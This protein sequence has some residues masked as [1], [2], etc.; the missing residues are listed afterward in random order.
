[1]KPASLVQLAVIG[2]LAGIVY[3]EES[4]SACLQ[5]L[6]Q[7]KQS[8]L[9]KLTA[10]GKTSND[11]IAGE[12]GTNLTA[13]FEAFKKTVANSFTEWKTAIGKEFGAA[14]QSVAKLGD[15]FQQTVDAFTPATTTTE[16]PGLWN[17]IKGYVKSK[18]D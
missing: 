11:A 1:M 17:R 15:A 13:E 4:E 18:I 8:M 14:E 7:F 12:T 6:E 9:E 2:L 5:E 3:S 10:F 16:S